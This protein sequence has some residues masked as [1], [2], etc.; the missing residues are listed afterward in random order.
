MPD[1]SLEAKAAEAGF[2]RIAGIDEAGRGPWAGPVVA[3]AVVFDGQF[4]RPADWPDWLAGLD[5]SKKLNRKKREVLFDVI[6]AGAACGI[7]R[8]E[9]EE[10]DRL[11]IL[12]ASLLAMRRAV[13]ALPAAPDYAL[14]D[15]T[16]APK[17]PCRCE[18]VIKGDGRSFSIAAA[19]VLA[20]VSRD[21][22]MAGLA[23]DY[24]GYGWE[25]NQGYGV[26]EHRAGLERLGVSPHHRKSFKPIINIL[27]D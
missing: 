25:R 4:G 15:G 19:S 22:I 3:A 9:V 18:T 7:G 2:I 17:L 13:E 1:F 16:H 5:D 6:L 23:A 24:P 10:I 14:I 20:K 11:N 21:E 27:G 26:P 8:A 12:Q